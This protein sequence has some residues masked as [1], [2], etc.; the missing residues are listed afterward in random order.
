[1]RSVEWW[2][3]MAPHCFFIAGVPEIK[4]VSEFLNVALHI[5][6]VAENCWMLEELPSVYITTSCEFQK[7]LFL[8]V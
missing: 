2:V 8:Q 6:I 7:G 3:A 4:A 5:L 1:M